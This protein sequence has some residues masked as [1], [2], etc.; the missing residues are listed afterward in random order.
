MLKERVIAE[1]K[2][3]SWGACNDGLTLRTLS[4]RAQRS[5]L[6]RTCRTQTEIAASL[7]RRSSQ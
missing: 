1:A 3:V 6:E 2:R 7:L 5:N 4:L